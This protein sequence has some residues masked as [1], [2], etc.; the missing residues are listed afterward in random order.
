MGRPIGELHRFTYKEHRLTY[1]DCSNNDHE[2][3][4]IPYSP[5]RG[6]QHG[7]AS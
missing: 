6:R 2:L 5:V 3:P 1:I 7:Q 4:G